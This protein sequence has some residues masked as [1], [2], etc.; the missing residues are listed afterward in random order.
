MWMRETADTNDT[1]M[2]NMQSRM[3]QLAGDKNRL[4]AAAKAAAED[5][6]HRYKE[7]LGPVA[8]PAPTCDA[9]GQWA[10]THALDHIVTP[11]ATVG[12]NADLI[13]RL[14]CLDGMPPLAR[15]LRD[16]DRAAWPH[17]THGFFRFRGNI[18]K[19][20]GRLRGLGS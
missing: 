11:Y 2:R 4:L 3:H 12:P 1:T 16:Y 5:V 17:A 10:Q 8:W 6:T 19:L 13:S 14:T 18:P 20:L 7:R 15:I 9:I